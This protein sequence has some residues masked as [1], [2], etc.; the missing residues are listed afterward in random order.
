VD[1]RTRRF[2]EH[3][4]PALRAALEADPDLPAALEAL[5]TQAR[6]AW[7]QLFAEE[8]L[9]DYVAARVDA[10]S[11]ASLRQLRAADLLLAERCAVADEAA[12]DILSREFLPR[13]DGVIARVNRSSAFREDVLS[14]LRE[15]LFV[16]KGGEPPK[17]AVYSGRGELFSFLAVTVTRLALRLAKKG[18]REVHEVDREQV[19]SD[20]ELALMKEAYRRAFK[21][22]F[23]DAW[24]GMPEAD[25]ELLRKHY[26]ESATLDEL[27]SLHSNHRATVAR[28]LAKAR[29][30]LVAATEALLAERLVVP[31]D[32]LDS[33]LRLVRSQM[34]VSLPA[35][36][37]GPS[38]L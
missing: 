12:I 17:I 30:S 18:A 22:A 26:L 37:R 8:R 9:L 1:S 32:E 27:A 19:G 28:W 7:P 23:V 25:R 24:R 10:A 15:L 5:V 20:P 35:L 6:E 14:A 29:E 3:A 2:I 11:A 33:V 36:L 31:R 16:A 4:N 34:T 13:L 21:L 38:D